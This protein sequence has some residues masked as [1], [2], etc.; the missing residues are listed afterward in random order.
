MGVRGRYR[1]G[2]WECLGDRPPRGLVVL[3]QEEKG[4]LGSPRALGKLL[5]SLAS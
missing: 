1:V 3:W 2:V 4:G 5:F